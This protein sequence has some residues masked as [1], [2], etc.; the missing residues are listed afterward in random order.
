M[1]S[2]DF[3]DFEKEGYQTIAYRPSTSNGFRYPF[4]LGEYIF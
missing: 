1:S 2:F 4:E 3:K